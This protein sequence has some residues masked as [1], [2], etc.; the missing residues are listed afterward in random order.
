MQLFPIKTPLI[1]SKDDL[2]KILIS[3]M[4]KAGIKPK[5]GDILVVTS[6]VVALTQGRIV[7]YK[8][9]KPSKKAEELAKKYS[10]DP[11]FIE[12]IL[13]E[14]D[15]VYGGVYRAILTMKD[16]VFVANAGADLSNAP[17][18]FA[19]LWPENPAIKA[20]KLK[21]EI[22][23]EFKVKIGVIISDSH[24]IPLRAGTFGFALTT[25]GFK[26]VID[27]RGKKDLFGKKMN[28]TRRAIADDLASAA[29]ILMG[30]TDWR[31]PAVLIR[32]SGIEIKDSVEN[33]ETL[34][35]PDECLYSSIYI[36]EVKKK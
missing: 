24:C 25:V 19:I 9:I 34:M 26:S 4:K 7:N 1:K 2:F 31:I 16:K 28:I 11:G 8:E 23:N 5:D 3:S 10:L 13:K 32:D 18:G 36:E 20:K 6:K 29:Q 35:P 15:A 21:K 30:E 22:E 12:I 27:E 14:A 33:S 17:E